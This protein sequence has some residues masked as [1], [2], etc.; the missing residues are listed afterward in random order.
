MKLSTILITL[1]LVMVSTLAMAPAPAVP[2]CQ[3]TYAVTVLAPSWSPDHGVVHD[4]Y[5]YVGRPRFLKG[6]TVKFGER[7]EPAALVRFHR[8]HG[9]G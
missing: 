4:R 1:T 5:E 8:V 3:E 9:H 7:Y 2:C 6:G